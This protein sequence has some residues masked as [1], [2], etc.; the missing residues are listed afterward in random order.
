MATGGIGGFLAFKLVKG[1][2]QVA[3]IAR[4][5]HLDAIV[6]N[7]LALDGPEG[8]ES[9]RPWIAT[10]DTSR[11]GKVDAIIFGVKGDGL[12]AAAKACIPMIGPDTRDGA[13]RT[14]HL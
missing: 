5:Q 8:S 11:V 6:E 1:G 3:T 9:I 7:G 10:D 12:E 2:H 13:N 14:A 4:G